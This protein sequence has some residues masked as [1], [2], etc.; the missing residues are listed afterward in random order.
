MFDKLLEPTGRTFH[1][2]LAQREPWIINPVKYKRY[3]EQGFATFSG[4][5][6]LVPSILEKLGYDPL[7]HYG[8]PPRTPYSSPELAKEYPLILIS[9]GR[10]R[11]YYHSSYRE[12]E[13]LRNLRPD[14]LLEIHP[15][16][17][18]ELLIADGDMVYIETPE[19]KVRQRA[20][21]TRGI[22]PRVVHADGHWWYP[23]MPGKDPCL[24][25]VWESNINAIAPGNSE[26]FDYEGD[27]PLRALLCRVYKAKE[28]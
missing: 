4:K 12:Q 16:T 17:A 28:F 1:G 25:G 27:N 2:L 10:I 19:G 6:E 18:M 22:H 24:F 20:R 3:E 11:Y 15:D 9:G 7:P 13:K 23:E 21:L 14:P 26:Y 5:I 8:E